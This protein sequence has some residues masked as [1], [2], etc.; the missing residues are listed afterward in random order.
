MKRLLILQRLHQAT[1]IKKPG[2]N[3][4]EDA[5][6]GTLTL[7]RQHQEAQYPLYHCITIENGGR[8]SS[9]SN[10]DKRIMPGVYH[11]KTSKTT[12]PIPDPYRPRGIG[13]L[14][15]SPKD[16][17]FETRRIFIHSGNYPQDTE[18][19]ILLQSHYDFTSN[20]GYGGGSMRAVKTLYDFIFHSP[21]DCVLCI[22]EEYEFFESP[23]IPDITL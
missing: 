5:T 1:D 7:F 20:P 12:V 2:S 3:K 18:G 16:P 4:I 23:R 6:I 15:T 22:K 9:V 13:I 21:Q 10:K 11:L 8:S 14:L 19:C 17:S